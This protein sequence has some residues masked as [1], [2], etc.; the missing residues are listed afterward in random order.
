EPGFRGPGI[1][2]EVWAMPTRNLGGFMALIPSPLGLGSVTLDDGTKTTGF[3]CEPAGLAGAMEITHHGGWRN[4][5]K[6][7]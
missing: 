6:T 7:K 3:I 5:L 4:Y 2:V 1:E